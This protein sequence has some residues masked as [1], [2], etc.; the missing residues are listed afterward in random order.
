MGLDFRDV[1]N[2]GFPDITFVALNSQTFPLFLNTGKGDFK[3]ATTESGLRNL[4]MGMSGFG[5]GLYDL[6][7]DGWKDM[8]VARG[9]VGSIE[10]PG[11]EIYQ[12]NSVFRNL[13]VSGK[14]EALADSASG[15]DATPIA[16]HRGC[17]FG[18]FNGD[19]RIDVVVTALSKPAEIW[20]NESPGA[21][22]W[23]DI[24]LEGTKS[25]RDGIGARIKVSSASLTQ[26]N[27]MTTSV[28]YASSSAGPV[29]F[30]LGVDGKA[31]SIE[32]HWPS[33]IVQVLK[34]VPAN[35]T[36]KVKEPSR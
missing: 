14:W 4:S 9:H 36:L 11:H 6:D 24:A 35:Q 1:N 10:L 13:G 15:L 19:G 29:H 32:I 23:L 28:G 22:H 27:H 25:N 5:S 8:F 18:D 3:E 21:A 33:G 2:D 12:H 20:M 16:L 34:D 26:Y 31:D 7:N 30:G 17:A